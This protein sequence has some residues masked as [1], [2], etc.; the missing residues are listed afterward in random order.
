[1]DDLPA[2]L[3]VK[4]GPNREQIYS[5]TSDDVSLGR[6]S[7]CTIPIPDPEVSRRHA[8]IRLEKNDYVLQDWGSTNGTFVNDQ[9]IRGRVTLYNGDEIR[10]GDTI[11]LQFQTEDPRFD[12][13]DW[14]QPVVVADD[15]TLVDGS[16]PALITEDEP[17]PPVVPPPEERAEGVEAVTAADLAEPEP[18]QGQCR[19]RALGCGCAFLVLLFLCMATIYFLDAYQGG[20]LLYCGP[21]R[22]FFEIILGPFGFAPICP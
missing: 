13:A 15:E 10:L 7:S 17:I 1:M 19:R 4:R 16:R 11:V 9:R 3:I 5:I 20:R 21:L 22:P 2:R 18:A 12:R 14:S 6:S 8:T